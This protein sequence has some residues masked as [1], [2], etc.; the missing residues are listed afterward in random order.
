[1]TNELAFFIDSAGNYLTQCDKSYGLDQGWQEVP[2][3]PEVSTQIW[4][5]KLKSWG[6]TPLTVEDYRTAVQKYLDSVAKEFGY[7][8]ITSAITYADEPSVP[9]FQQEGLVMRSWRSLVWDYCYSQLALV[10]DGEI[11][12][13]TIE[14]LIS[15]LPAL[16]LQDE[17]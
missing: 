10:N 7:D 15:E 5:F 17:V 1:M 9:K 13:P 14:Q 11:E 2:Y 6:V 3:P 8:N 16:S 12:A 4:N